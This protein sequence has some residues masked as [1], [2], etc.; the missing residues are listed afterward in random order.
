MANGNDRF[1]DIKYRS[2]GYEFASESSKYQK[3]DLQG[4]QNISKPELRTLIDVSFFLVHCRFCKL[5]NGLK[6]N[7]SYIF[8]Y[9]KYIENPQISTRRLLAVFC[10]T[11]RQS[12]R[13]SHYGKP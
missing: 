6:K 9:F 5:T 10:T 8:T 1:I 11:L 12:L 7:S 13:D 4:Q 2:H 3:P